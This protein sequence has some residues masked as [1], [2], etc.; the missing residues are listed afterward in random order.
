METK[1]YHNILLIII[2]NKTGN[3]TPELI[4]FSLDKNITMY[5]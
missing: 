3:N 4:L 2:K 5:V 1:T